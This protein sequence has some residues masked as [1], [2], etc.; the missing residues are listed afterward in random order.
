ML[1]G[2]VDIVLLDVDLGEE[3][4]LG[5]VEA[6]RKQ[7][8]EGKILVVTAGVSRLEAGRLVERGCAGIILKQERPEVLLERIRAIHGCGAVCLGDFV[9][10]RAARGAGIPAF[11]RLL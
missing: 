4:A 9:R 6:A 10:A 2:S 8:F 11:L 3:R 5:F 1:Q 7:A